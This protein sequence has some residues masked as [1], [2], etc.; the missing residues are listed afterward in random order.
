I[1]FNNADI[2][3]VEFTEKCPTNEAEYLKIELLSEDEYGDVR[4]FGKRK[5]NNDVI[6]TI[7]PL[8]KRERVEEPRQGNKGLK[9]QENDRK[10]CIARR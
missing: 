10:W 4:A 6:E 3:L 8:G 9:S 1:T 5:R 7:E 2:R